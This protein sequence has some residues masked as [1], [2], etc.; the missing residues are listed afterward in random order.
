MERF[1]S[2]RLRDMISILICLV[3]LSLIAIGVLMLTEYTQKI[4]AHAAATG[5]VYSSEI[6]VDARSAIVSYQAKIQQMVMFLSEKQQ[7]SEA[8]FTSNLRLLDIDERFSEV[9]FVRYFRDSVE[10]DVNSNVFDKTRENSTVLQ[11]AKQRTAACAGV[12]EDKTYSISAM[13]FY[14]PLDDNPFADAVVFFCFCEK[15]AGTIGVHQRE[16]V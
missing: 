13:A 6:A 9:M 12:V 5:K 10:Y 3:A 4:T 11:L 2:K 1:F 15:R 8:A 16:Y 14:A 7:E